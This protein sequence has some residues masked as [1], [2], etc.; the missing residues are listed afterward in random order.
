MKSVRAFGLPLLLAALSIS[1]TQ[2]PRAQIKS[3]L[4]QAETDAE[5]RNI[6]ALR[7]HISDHYADDQGRD[8]QAVLGVVALHLAHSGSVH[9]LTRIRT[10][11]L[12]RPDHAEATLYLAMADV[13]I[14]S[15][16]RL[17]GLRAELYRID[18]V[19]T[20]EGRSD[21]KVTRAVWQRAKP[22][23]FLF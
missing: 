11:T 9:L 7:K 5:A 20:D 21:C 8:A 4:R 12:L 15:E 17:S 2:D 13:P 18:L 16:E 14:E 22:I 23:D 1:C 10:V 6:V 19:L 3:L